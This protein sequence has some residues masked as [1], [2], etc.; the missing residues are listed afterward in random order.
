MPKPETDGNAPLIVW[1]RSSL[2]LADNPALHAAHKTRRPL[3]FLYTLDDAA[4]GRPL[5][6]AARWW[7]GRSLA[8]LAHDLSARDA[9]LV[10]RRGAADECI[11]GV[12]RESG[13]TGVVCNRIHHEPQRALA[14]R[15][16]ARVDGLGLGFKSF[17]AD[18]LVEPDDV[19]KPGGSGPRVFTPFWKRILARGTPPAPLPA[20]EKLRGGP[21]V[22]SESLSDWKL[23]PTPDWAGGLRATWQPGEAGARAQ[24]RRFLNG[25]LAGYATRRDRPDHDNTSHLSPHLRFGEISPRQVWQAAAFQGEEIPARIQDVSKFLSELGWREFS[26][27]LLARHPLLWRDNL[28]SKFDEFPWRRD[29]AALHAW[30]RGLTGYPMVDAGM[31]ELWRTGTM[32]NRVRMVAASFLIK[33]L[34]I[35]WREGETWFWDT[36]VDADP[37]NNPASWQWVAGCGA[38][39]APY[40]RIFNPVLQ[41]EKFDPDGAY[42]RSFVPELKEMP[43]PLI[44]RPWTAKPEELARAGVRLGE[45]YP[46]PIVDHAAARARALDAFA[47]VS[48]RH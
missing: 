15:V 4:D 28:Q 21:N 2:R 24:L 33:H 12:A 39:S 14:D 45:T 1:L 32:H 29:N 3:V 35:D 11:A 23:E 5:G 38:D 46:H 6:G 10:L 22:S 30:K 40:F 9:R 8:A 19:A 47:K 44:H 27:H 36:L 42:V 18:L 16:R 17:A 13:A 48:G 43:A 31:R 7:L 26:H 41:G 20:P 34:L 25:G 37:A